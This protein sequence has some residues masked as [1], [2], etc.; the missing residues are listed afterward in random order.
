MPASPLFNFSGF[1]SFD[2]GKQFAD[3][4]LDYMSSQMPRTMVD[5][6][7]WCEA[8]WIHGA[9]GTYRQACQRI[10]RFFLTEIEYSDTSDEGDSTR[11]KDFHNNTLRLFD[12]LG[13]LGDDFLCYGNSFSSVYIPFHRFLSCPRCKLERPIRWWDYEF[14]DGKFISKE[15]CKGHS[16]KKN[17]GWKGVLKRKDRPSLNEKDVKIIRWSPHNMVMMF[18]PISYQTKYL[19]N[20]PKDIVAAV[21]AGEKFWL[22]SLPW[23][24]VQCCIQNK[25]FEFY[26]GVV[27]HMKEDTVAGIHNAGW[28][29]PRVLS[30]LRQ[31]YY[32]Q[33]LKRQDEAIALD[34]II[35]L[36]VITPAPIGKTDPLQTVNQARFRA[37]VDH[38]LRQRRKDPAAWNV[39][40]YPISYEAHGAEAKNMSPVE[41][42]TLGT[43]E[44]LNAIGI[45]AEMYRATLT[46]QAAPM[47]L[48]LFSQSW[49]HWV[50][51]INGWLDWSCDIISSAFSWDKCSARMKP[52]TLADDIEL[53]QIQMQMA[54]ARQISYTTAVGPLGI[55]MKKEVDRIMEE[56]KLRMQA[57]DK[58][59]R[60]I[61][62]RQAQGLLSPG[63]GA[64]T[65][66]SM[67]Q[68][69]GAGGAPAGGGGMGALQTEGMG[70]GDMRQQAMEIA[71][72]LV[73]MPSNIQRRQI[74]SQI[75][76]S[77]ETMHA[78]VKSKMQEIRSQ[79]GSQG[80]DALASGAM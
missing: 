55:D 14:H 3:P 21:Q 2:P 6:L 62:N 48:R 46:M 37:S 65:A 22:E 64:A 73:R 12:C 40:P 58:F 57:Q 47:A 80:R 20:I 76:A 53:R 69:A 72:Q 9:N 23:K 35:P 27:F 15:P 59:Q 75:R 68:P 30:T 8:A 79:A 10:S 67:G 54:A 49:G 1:G 66:M 77:S 60:D 32:L 18:N 36:R 34:Y 25:K 61:E 7:R 43:D 70:P 29:L 31:L 50:S 74:L 13:N 63:K 45:P 24:F 5:V 41:L 78:L 28:G 44:F 56:D 33:V 16:G 51:N 17:C 52:S 71:N 26:P 38:M 39:M 19:M 4:F 11:W 42:K